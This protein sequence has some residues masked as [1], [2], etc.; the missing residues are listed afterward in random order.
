MIMS[1][2]SMVKLNPRHTKK[3]QKRYKQE[4]KNRKSYE[5]TFNSKIIRSCQRP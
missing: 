4:Y 3:K 1:L 5:R 2:V